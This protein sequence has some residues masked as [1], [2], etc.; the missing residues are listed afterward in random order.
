VKRERVVEGDA[1]EDRLEVVKPVGTA[2]E[3][4]ETEIDLGVGVA[5]GGRH[6]DPHVQN[7]KNRPQKTPDF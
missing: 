3:D 5:G 7:T 4:K 2:G 6:A 1:V